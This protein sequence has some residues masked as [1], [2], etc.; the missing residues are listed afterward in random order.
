MNRQLLRLLDIFQFALQVDSTEQQRKRRPWFYLTARTPDSC[1]QTL[2]SAE[3]LAEVLA[4]F[5]AARYFVGLEFPV[6]PLCPPLTLRV[7]RAQPCASEE[8]EWGYTSEAITLEEWSSGEWTDANLEA[9]LEWKAERR[10]DEQREKER[11][12]GW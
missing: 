11:H 3:T 7:V 6:G 9:F 10:D 2:A 5:A 4:A 12:G 1:W 8:G